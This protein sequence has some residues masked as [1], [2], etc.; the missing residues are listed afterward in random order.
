MSVNKIMKRYR[1]END[2]GNG[3]V[4]GKLKDVHENG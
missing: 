3:N 2:G 4:E 1:N